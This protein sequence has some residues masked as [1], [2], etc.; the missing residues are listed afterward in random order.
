MEQNSITDIEKRKYIIAGI[1]TGI[2]SRKGGT[3]E[4]QAREYLS[5]FEGVPDII[6]GVNDEFIDVKRSENPHLSHFDCEYIWTCEQF[7]RQLLSYDGFMLHASGVVYEDKAY[8]FSAPSGTGKSTHTQLWCRVFGDAAYIIN[9]DK[10]VIRI[11]HDR[12]M[13]FGTPWSGKTNQNRNTGVPLGGICFI[14]RAAENH[15]EEI[16]TKAAA[17]RILNQT[18]RP[19]E[20]KDMAKLLAVLDK[21]LCKTKIY[22]MGCNIS[23]EAVKVAFEGMSEKKFGANPP[24]KG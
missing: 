3:I 11:V 23:E 7:C 21:V 4:V 18:I 19:R 24:E 13:V 8:L 14:E 1:K 15:I 10:P 12:A 17:F 5:D 9:D 16:E 22:K 6:T 2:I 20:E